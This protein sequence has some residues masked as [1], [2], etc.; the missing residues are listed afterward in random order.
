MF[1][2]DEICEEISRKRRD[3][4]EDMSRCEWSVYAD[5]LDE[6][7]SVMQDEL[8]RMREQ[9]WNSSKVGTQVMLY[10]DPYLREYKFHTVNGELQTKPEYK[11]LYDPI[12]ECWK[13]LK[14][15]IF[16][17]TFFP[18]IRESSIDEIFKQHLIYASMAYQWGKL[19]M[20][21][22]ELVASKVFNTA[23]SLFDKC[24]GMVWFKVYLNKKINLSKVR[25]SAGKKGGDGKAKIYKI[26]QDKFVELI[27]QYAPEEGWKS[28]VA[29]VNDLIDPLWLFIKKSNFVVKGQSEKYGLTALDK[30]KL[31]DT[32]LKQWST[33]VENIRLAFDAT[34]RRKK[35]CNK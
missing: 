1:F 9:F 29:A 35:S 20:P 21:D 8:A 28:R 32:I 17:E 18:L 27:Y 2:L 14:C 34:V 16:R 15:R 6:N 26:I 13:E 19:I 22:N 7:Y 10:S 12:Q 33:K 4:S 23:S 3:L 31:A 11:E 30:D 24:I 25:V 5:I